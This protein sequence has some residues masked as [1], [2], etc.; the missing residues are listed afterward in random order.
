[1]VFL[2]WLMVFLFND[3][4]LEAVFSPVRLLSRVGSSCP[5]SL[6]LDFSAPF[7]L[8]NKSAFVRST[9]LRD[10]NLTLWELLEV[11]IMLC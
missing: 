2:I 4:M 3:P 10:F 11:M 7:R 8:G 9:L 5:L 6:E 1:M